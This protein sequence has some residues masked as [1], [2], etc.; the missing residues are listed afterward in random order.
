M[1]DI[2][3]WLVEQF[4]MFSEKDETCLDAK[5]TSQ[6]CA[7]LDIVSLISIEWLKLEDDSNSLI[8]LSSSLSMD[9]YMLINPVIFWM[10]YSIESEDRLSLFKL[11]Y[12]ALKDVSLALPD[13][14]DISVVHVI[15]PIL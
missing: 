11:A 9:L 12:K 3:S 13:G 14:I 6:V 7:L 15:F 5:D 2:I 8:K 4:V 1:N 10:N